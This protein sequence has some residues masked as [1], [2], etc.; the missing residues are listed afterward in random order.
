[1]LCESPD[2]HGVVG[3]RQGCGPMGYEAQPNPHRL[4]VTGPL[5]DALYERFARLYNGRVDVEVVK[6]RRYA[7]RRG[8]TRA[9]VRDRRRGSDRRWRTPDWVFPP[10]IA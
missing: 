3:E 9:V 2:A 7:D 5:R 4:I 10:E 8:T 6:D 1:M